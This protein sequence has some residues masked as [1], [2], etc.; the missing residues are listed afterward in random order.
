MSQA[1]K[2]KSKGRN[3]KSEEILVFNAT[4]FPVRYDSEN[5]KVPPQTQQIVELNEYVQSAID[6]GFFAVRF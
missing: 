3:K 2:S 6:K 4:R 1:N 5:R